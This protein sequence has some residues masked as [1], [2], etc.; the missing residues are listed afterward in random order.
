MSLEEKILKAEERRRKKEEAA[1]LKVKTK[2]AEPTE[3]ELV[4]KYANRVI[5][6]DQYHGRGKIVEYE[7]SVSK[8][9]W[10]DQDF[11]FSVV[12]QS[13]EQKREFLKFLISKFNYSV[14]DKENYSIQII[15][16]LE[17]AKSMGIELKTEESK[18]YPTG[19]LDLMPFVLDPESIP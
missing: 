1:L 17:L 5:R 18:D 11:F 12:F 10:M 14:E 3:A 4:R 7:K 8:N 19:N 13:S 6:N 15:N 16:G 2:K 9:L